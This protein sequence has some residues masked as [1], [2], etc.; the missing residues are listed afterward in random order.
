MM[1]EVDSAFDACASKKEKKK[2]RAS[3]GQL[4]IWLSVWHVATADT[5]MFEGS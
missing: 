1:C 2:K 3:R 5:S 4:A